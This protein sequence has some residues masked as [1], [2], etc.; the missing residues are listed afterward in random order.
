M[1]NKEMAAELD[2]RLLELEKPENQG[3]GFTVGDWV[4]LFISGILGPIILLFWGW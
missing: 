3:A 1:D 2:R 4:F